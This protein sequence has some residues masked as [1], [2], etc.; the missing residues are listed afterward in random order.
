MAMLLALL[1]AASPQKPPAN[2][3]IPDEL[4]EKRERELEAT[5]GQMPVFA[6]P[7]LSAALGP[8]KPQPG[9]WVEYLVRQKG[10]PDVR[11]RASVVGRPSADG[12]FW[13]ELATLAQTGIAGAVKLRVHG[14][15]LSPKDIER[16]FVMMAGQQPLEVPLD[17]LDPPAPKPPPPVKVTHRGRE[18][19]AVRAGSYR[20]DVLEAG[21]MRVW[22]ASSVPLWGLVKA[23]SPKQSVEL[24]GA[25]ARGAHTVFPPGWGDAGDDQGI[26]SETTK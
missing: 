25:S 8:M 17:Q 4:R 7:L 3:I 14:D 1:L 21:D 12:G 13:L 16:M 23:R 15:P 6:N 11:V 26:G 2:V 20:A 19:I 5:P 24:L 22:R 9:A 18:A 10:R